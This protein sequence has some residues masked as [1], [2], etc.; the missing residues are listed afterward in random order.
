MSKVFAIAVVIFLASGCKHSVDR[1]QP[2]CFPKRPA[3]KPLTGAEQKAL[4]DAKLRT[5]ASCHVAN[6]QCD[7][8]VTMSPHGEIVVGVTFAIVKGYPPRCLFGP[9]H[10]RS[11]SIL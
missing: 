7:F 9:D 6:T 4:S 11:I 2:V 5:S 3:S 10:V 8:D 1:P